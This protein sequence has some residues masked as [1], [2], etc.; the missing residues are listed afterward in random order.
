MLLWGNSTLS[1]ESTAL[2]DLHIRKLLIYMRKLLI[3]IAR[4]ALF[5][6]NDPITWRAMYR[7]IDPWLRELKN[8]RALYEYLYKGDQH[9]NTIEDAELN[10]LAGIERGEYRV[11]IYIKP[12]KI[13]KWMMLDA[14]ITSTTASFSEVFEQVML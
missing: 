12:T 6:P 10:T 2:Q 11:Q 14:V 7:R 8:Q 9:A 5:E 3:P 1:R 13:I 4:Y